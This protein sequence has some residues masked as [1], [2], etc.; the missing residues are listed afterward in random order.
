MFIDFGV[1]ELFFSSGESCTY[2]TFSSAGDVQVN[3][4]SM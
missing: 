2:V 4:V 1:I 3:I